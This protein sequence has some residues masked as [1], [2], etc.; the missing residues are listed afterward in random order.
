MKELK[1]TVQKTFAL[2]EYFTP[3]KHEWG[4]TELA[5]EIG[6][7]KSTIYRFLADM[8][9]S[10][11]LYKDN[12]TERYSLS[13]KLY[14]LGNRV[15]LKSA[16]VEKSHPVLMDVASK[17][18]E[19]V[20][21]GILKSNKVFYIDKVESPQGLKI[22]T[23]IGSSFPTYPTALGKTLLA[24]LPDEERERSL[25]QIFGESQPV[26]FTEH[27]ITTRPELEAELN[28]IRKQGFAIDKEEYEIGLICVSIPIL[29]E[30]NKVV[31][32][33]SASGPSNRFKEDELTNYVS[34]L[35]EGAAKIQQKIGYFIL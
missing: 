34:I 21:I 25:S 6:A 26:A 9:R 16:F 8:Q 29:N 12:N 22:S 3:Q 5:N 10:G 32:S 20:H 1:S 4:V 15:R 30:D 7:N 17:I 28:Q 11:I 23:N 31:A 2:L 33:L 18:S 35:Q 13:L 27:T 14:E 19:T 24:Y